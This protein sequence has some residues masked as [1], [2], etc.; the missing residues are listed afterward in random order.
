[1]SN[2]H[3]PMDVAP[4]LEPEVYSQS[5][6]MMRSHPLENN[7]ILHPE[8]EV[9]EA[10]ARSTTLTSRSPLGATSKLTSKV[11]SSSVSDE[12]S[13]QVIFELTLDAQVSNSRA[14]LQ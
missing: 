9:L 1:M 8:S 13:R 11:G 5:T 6:T 14:Y 4:A 10:D 3:A 12:A 2:L 7:T